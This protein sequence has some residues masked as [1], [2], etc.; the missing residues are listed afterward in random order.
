MSNT[1][2]EKVILEEVRRH[3]FGVI[4]IK[5]EWKEN[6]AIVHATENYLKDGAK[7]TSYHQI[8]MT[9]KWCDN[10]WRI[11]LNLKD[12]TITYTPKF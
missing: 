9:W 10:Y 7:Q 12:S 11:D 2:P 4:L 5:I 3:I 1:P 8:P 6:S